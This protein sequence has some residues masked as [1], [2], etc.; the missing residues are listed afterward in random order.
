MELDPTVVHQLFGVLI[1]AFALALLANETEL[2]TFSTAPYL[3]AG[4][5]I[6]LGA[7][8]FA[9]PWLFH[10]GDFGAEG[11]QHSLQGFLAMVAGGLEAY[12]VARAPENIW[13]GLIIPV[14][15]TTFGAVFILHAQHDGGD[16]LLQ[17]VQH[18]ILGV[19]LILSALVKAAS[20]FHVGRGNWASTGWLIVLLAVALQLFFYVEGGVGVHAAHG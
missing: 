15:L 4:A 17:T 1:A 5:L 18:R 19:T 9:D 3:P 13:L 16:A 12:R 10:G 8:L 11:R 6:L 2:F 7:L 14:L 20:S